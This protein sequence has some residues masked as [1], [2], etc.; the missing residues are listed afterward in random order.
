VAAGL[1]DLAELVVQA[2]DRVG[3]AGQLADRGGEGEERG[4]LVPGVF[5]DPD[6]LGVLAPP[7]R[8][9][10]R[11]QGVE[12]GL[13]GRRRARRPDA[14]AAPSEH[15]DR[16]AH[17]ITEAASASCQTRRANHGKCARAKIRPTL[18][19]TAGEH[20]ELG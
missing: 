16:T 20:A 9:R 6:R 15:Q 18:T 13:G 2:L 4:E 19:R 1:G 12:R 5:P 7:G 8:L 17:T 11:G 10:E 3:G 14:A